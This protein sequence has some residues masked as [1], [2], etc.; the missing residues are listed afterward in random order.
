M[1]CFRPACPKV[2]PRCLARLL[3][4]R[5][6]FG[7]R[8][9]KIVVEPPSCLRSYQRH[10]GGAYCTRHPPILHSSNYAARVLIN[11]AVTAEMI[12]PCLIMKSE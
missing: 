4:A 3:E 10:T 7:V 12:N 8:L 2:D 11:A 1:S 6:N 5:G 9:A